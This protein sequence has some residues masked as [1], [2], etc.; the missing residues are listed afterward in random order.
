MLLGRLRQ[1]DE[2]DDFVA[3][4]IEDFIADAEELIAELARAALASDAATFRDR[5]HALRSSA[6]H[7]GASALFDLCLGW[8]G[9]GAAELA[10]R[11][12]AC[13]ARL[14]AEFERLRAAL[15]AELAAQRSPDP[16]EPPTVSRP[17]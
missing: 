13:V 3:Q 16:H 17:R 14:T 15:L 6:A 11:G 5:A 9:I 7:I 12:A 1:L 2:Q 4:L 8:R 10:E